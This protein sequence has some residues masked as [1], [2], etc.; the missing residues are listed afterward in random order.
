[1]LNFIHC[2]TLSSYMRLTLLNKLSM[3]KAGN[4]IVIIFLL[5]ATGGLSITMHYCGQSFASFSLFSTPKPCCDNGCD[6]C[7]NEF[8]FNKITD[9]FTVSSS[10]EMKPQVSDNPIHAIIIFDLYRSLAVTSFAA[11]ISPKKFLFLKTGDFPVAFGNFL[12]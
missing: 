7:H 1:M 10:E 11:P 8:S 9:N 4:L 2:K 5:I 6:K 3:K 12:C